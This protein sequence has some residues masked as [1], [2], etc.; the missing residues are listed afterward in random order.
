[1]QIGV[2][3]GGTFTDLVTLEAEGIRFVKVPST[4]ANPG[5]A[6]IQACEQVGLGGEPSSSV[7]RHGTTVGTNA[8]LART[9]A[10]VALV[11]TRGFE[12][13]LSIARQ[14]RPALY[15][16]VSHRAQPLVADGLR[17]PVTERLDCRGEVVVPLALGDLEKIK[18]D[19]AECKAESVVIGF[20]HAYAAP[21][22][23]AAAAAALRDLG[24]PV[25]CSAAINPEHREFERLST[26]AANAYLAPLM[27]RYLRRLHSGLGP[28]ALQVVLGDGGAATWQA[29]ADMPVRTVLSGP[30]GGVRAAYLLGKMI[31]DENIISLDMGGT[32]TDVALIAGRIPLTRETRIGDLP[33][34]LHQVDVATVGAGGG[35]IAWRDQGGLLRVG[36]SSAG[37]RPGPACFGFGG[38]ATVTDAHVVCGRMVPHRF[39]G[40]RMALRAAAAATAVSSLA[41]QVG[42][43]PEATARGILSVANTAMLTALRSV[44][45]ARGIDPR[46]YSLLAFGGA[47]PL[48]AAELATLLGVSR[49]IIPPEPGLV[50]ALGVLAAPVIVRAAKAL[51]APLDASLAGGVPAVVDELCAQ[52]MRAA[53]AEGELAVTATVSFEMRYVGQSYEIS[54]Q[55]FAPREVLAEATLREVLGTL[56]TPL[57]AILADAFTA[58][59]L[60]QLGFAFPDRPIELVQVVVAGEGTAPVVAE[61]LEKRLLAHAGRRRR[62]A[63]RRPQALRAHSAAGGASSGTPAAQTVDR[64]DLLPG[65]ELH[66]PAVVCEDHAT[67][68]V[69]ADF[70]ATADERG[71]L[72]LY[73]RPGARQ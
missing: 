24:I 7:V 70:L 55:P 28:A 60:A 34:R 65:D 39:L 10:R 61:E 51:L 4:P 48:H 33:I 49:A 40:G 44:S 63:R 20:L 23:E 22:H 30:A 31:G 59:H 67:T 52:V 64:D 8:L 50:S 19:L 15:D 36:P 37:A 14:N 66:G 17:F 18:R 29:A 27:Q 32:S 42:L 25:C 71:F 56:P 21:H 46:G 72:F 9:G 68:W 62:R 54:V 13:V 53:A 57:T 38:P 12:D 47:G 11:A 69:P 45:V 41:A 43:S 3:T 16:P 5:D 2:D 26:A 6:V 35:S 73:A 58:A 1:M